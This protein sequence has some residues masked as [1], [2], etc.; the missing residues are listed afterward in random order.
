MIQEIEAI[1]RVHNVKKI[2]T[3]KILSELGKS[4]GLTLMLTQ[5]CNLRCTYCYGGDSGKFGIEDGGIMTKKVAFAAIDRL[6]GNDNTNGNRY[7]IT[8]FGGEP[9]LNK[10]LMSAIFDYCNNLSKLHG[11]QFVYTMTTNGTLLDEDTIKLLINNN[12]SILLSLDGQK[13]IHDKRRIFRDEEGSFD[14]VMENIEKLKTNG[15]GFSVRATLKGDDFLEIDNIVNFFQKIGDRKAYVSELSTYNDDLS[16]FYID[17][18]ETHKMLELQKNQIKITENRF[19]SG[20]N[21]YYMPFINVLNKINMTYSYP[22]SCGFMRGTTTVSIHG[23]YYPCHRFVGMSGFNFG[24]VFTGR[25]TEK[26]MKIC[27]EIDKATLK[28]GRCFAKYICA[29]GCVRDIA[30][31]NCKFIEYPDEYCDLMREK[32]A[33]YLVIYRK[34]LLKRPDFFR[35]C[36][37][38]S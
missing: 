27:E 4:G 13:H 9:L 25:D 33:D 10:S 24:N 16:D 35:K 7:Q 8:L 34:A 38:L 19:L 1:I 15:L 18:A 2:D 14:T 36:N 23:D 17:V 26:Y 32:V 5:N 37:T 6:V 21:P 30:K 20:D 28:C 3:Y 11:V 29:R 31:N 12:V 22:I